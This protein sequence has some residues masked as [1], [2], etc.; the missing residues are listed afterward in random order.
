VR[1]QLR[2]HLL[3]VADDGLVAEKGGGDAAHF[4]PVG[5][6]HLLEQPRVVGVEIDLVFMDA[7]L[8]NFPARRLEV[9]ARRRAMRTAAAVEEHQIDFAIVPRTRAAGPEARCQ[10][11]EDEH[12][13]ARRCRSQPAGHHQDGSLHH[14]SDNVPRGRKAI[15]P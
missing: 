5:G 11:N 3:R 4:R 9:V 13:D 7:E 15:R 1:R 14:R 8:R 6:G 12:Q 10:K 2:V